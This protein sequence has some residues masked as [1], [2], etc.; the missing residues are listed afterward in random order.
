ML[1]GARTRLAFGSTTA[2]LI[3]MRGLSACKALR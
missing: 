1:W 2:T 3:G